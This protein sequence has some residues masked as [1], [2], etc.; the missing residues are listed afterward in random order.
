MALT[1]DM[2]KEL[3]LTDE[4]IEAVIAAHTET[5]DGIKADLKVAEENA[6]G[7]EDVQKELDD[8]KAV[9]ADAE[10]YKAKY[11]QEHA[12][13][14]AYKAGIEEERAMQEK[15]DL[16][17]TLL[18]QLGI[19]EGRIDAILKITDWADKTVKDGALENAEALA[20]AAKAEY[21]AF[22]ATT[23]TEGAEVANP[24]ENN[25]DRPTKAE[26]MAIADTAERQKAIAENHELFGF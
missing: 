6:A 23:T 20:E 16:Y 10:D 12:D 19:D 24:P 15:R 2:L 5:V 17:R 11:E 1:R 4:Q 14:E 26:I 9:I 21:A 18:V 25:G 7:L 3:N 8:A 22:I 13:F